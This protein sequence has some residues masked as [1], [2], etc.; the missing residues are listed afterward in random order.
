M[1]GRDAR[2]EDCY[3]IRNTCQSWQVHQLP[4]TCYIAVLA[5]KP[6]MKML[7]KPV[8]Q[9][10]FKILHYNRQTDSKTDWQTDWL[11]KLIPLQECIFLYFMIQSLLFM[12]NSN[13]VLQV[14]LIFCIIITSWS[15][16]SHQI[17]WW[18]NKDIDSFKVLDDPRW[19][20]R[21][22]DFWVLGERTQGF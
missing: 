10:I 4:M 2:R 12:N 17:S 19:W 8:I 15:I 21:G 3:Q 14:V 22:K 13:T 11:T 5:V 9:D 16:F 7:T 18:I 1:W 6:T 20:Q